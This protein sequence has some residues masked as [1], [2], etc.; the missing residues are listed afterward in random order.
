MTDPKRPREEI[1]VVV[2][3]GGMSAERDVSLVSGREC[4]KGLRDAGYK[5]SEL[6]VGRSV[7]SDLQALKPDV[8]FNALHGRFGEDGSIQGLLEYL[9]VPYT[10]SGVL[11][12][13]I[14]MNKELVKPIF[15]AAGVRM[16]EGRVVDRLQAAKSHIM[17]PP[18]V[19]KP[20]SEGSSVGVFIVEQGANRPPQE[21][22]SD[23]WSLGDDVLVERF[24]PGRELTVAVMGEQ[25]L[26]V[27]DIVATH[28]FYDYESK[29]ADGG[30]V[31][32][33]P[34][35]ISAAVE[36]AAKEMALAAH[37]SI[38]CRGVS[39]SDLRFDESKG[40]DGLYLL[41]VNTQPGMTPTSLVPEQA[42]YLGTD[43]SELVAWMVEDASC[44]R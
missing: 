21:I 2:L 15:R 35:D 9:N 6:D 4:A 11:A 25:A 14:A 33:L 44:G 41:E 23:D 39:R 3:K 20:V 37:Q 19:I 22:A 31:H 29:Y 16:P 24:I 17:E 43:F 10:H 38:G 13:S 32:I 12:S 8:C 28:E 40:V 18:Y 7:A 5:V 27:T 34:A 26:C 36:Q 42:A 1:H 30:S